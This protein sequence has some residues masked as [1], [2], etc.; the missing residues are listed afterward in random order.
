MIRMISHLRKKEQICL[1]SAFLFYL[2]FQ[3]IGCCPLTLGKGRSSLLSSLI[4]MP[5]AS[6]NTL[7]DTPRNNAFPSMWVPLNSV[8]FITKISKPSRPSMSGKQQGATE[9]EESRRDPQWTSWRQITG[10]NRNGL[11]LRWPMI[12][13]AQDFLGVSTERCISRKILQFHAK[14]HLSFP[15][16]ILCLP[17]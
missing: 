17:H 12:L 4:Q 9:L 7:T 11:H 3:P 5:I 8:K 6:R 10:T 16:P 13:V 15:H 1:F 14:Q 2:D